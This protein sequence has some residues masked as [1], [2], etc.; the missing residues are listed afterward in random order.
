MPP[1]PPAASEPPLQILSD[2]YMAPAKSIRLGKPGEAAHGLADLMGI[3]EAHIAAYL[4]DPEGAIKREFAMHGSA[5]DKENLRKVLDG[6]FGDGKALDTLVEHEHAKLARLKRHHVLALRLYTTQSYSRINN[7]LRQDPPTRPHPFAATTYFISEG[8]KKLRAVAAERPDAYQVRTFWRGMKDLGL[9][10]EFFAHGGTEYACMSTSASKDVACN[11]ALSKC[12]LVFKY[13]TPD[14]MSRGADVAFLS[15]YE[16]EAEVLYP[17]L[18]YL[19]SKGTVNEEIGGVM[20]LVATVE[21]IF[22][23]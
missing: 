5:A 10:A 17:P 15:V 16:S 21:P 22:P 3:G 19:R 1:P 4:S 12:P 7:P 18:T 8:I 20:M 2:K 14:F 6:V 13:V 23:S 11:F 9:S